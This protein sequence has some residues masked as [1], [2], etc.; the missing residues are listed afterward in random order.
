MSSFASDLVWIS[1]GLVGC[2]T[3]VYTAVDVSLWLA[4]HFFAGLAFCAWYGLCRHIREI[5]LSDGVC[6]FRTLLRPRRLEVREIIAV[7]LMADADTP[8]M[9][10]QHGG[11]K[12]RSVTTR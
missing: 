9:I 3:A 4:L 10:V 1:A 12:D 11:R 2:G 5:R 6:E 7:R 8:A